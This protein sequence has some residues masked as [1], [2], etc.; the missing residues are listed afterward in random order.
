MFNERYVIED[1]RRSLMEVKG[2]V[3]THV[4]D[5]QLEIFTS[6]E[7]LPFERRRDGA[8]RQ[9]GPGD[10]WGDLFDCA[11]FHCTA[12][13]PS[14]SIGQKL[15][16][17]LDI[18]G[19]G[20][21]Y[22]DAGCPVRGITNVNSGFDRAMGNPGKRVVP[23]ADPYTGREIADFWMD[24]GCNDLVGNLQDDGRIKE[25]YIASCDETARE[26]FYDGIV[27][28]TQAEMTPQVD[29]MRY[30]LLDT[31]SRCHRLLRRYTQE[32]YRECLKLTRRQLEKK[33]GDGAGLSLTAFGHAHIDLAWLW[34][35]RETRRKGARTFATALS[36]MERYPDYRFA[37]S[38]GQLYQWVKED[39][40]ALY[41][42]VRQ[43][44]SAGR[45]EL[46]GAMWVESDANLVSGESLV[47]QL[48]YG[49][50]FWEKEFGQRSRFVWM[51]D[52]FGYSAAMPQIF[53]KSEIT[54]FATIK[55]SWNL[56]NRFPYA[57]FRWRGIDGSEVLV[58]MPP[59]GNYVS[60]ATPKSVFK[61]RKSLAESGQFG[62]ALLPFGIGDGGGGP[63]P[64]HLEYLKRE[65]NLPGLCPIEQG[66][67]QG[68]F[69]RLAQRQDSLPV[70]QNEMYLERHLGVYTSAA[71]NKKYNRQME[72]E[73]RNAEMLSAF[74]AR[75][76]GM[77]Y[78]QRE[79]EELWKETLL[80]QFHDILPGSSIQR[81]YDESLARYAVMLE[82]ARALT[83]AAAQRLAQQVDTG[84]AEKPAVVF[85]T[86]SFQ[87]DCWLNTPQ[88]IL[89]V[90]V[91][92][93][94]YTVVDMAQCRL[95]GCKPADNRVL[96]NE[97][98]RAEFA[99]DGSLVRLYRKDLER[100]L[101]K[102]P[103]N[104][105]LLYRDV[106]NAWNLQYDYTNQ[107]PERMVLAEAAGERQGG[108]GRLRQRYEYQDT[109]VELTWILRLGQPFLEAE[110]QA[111]WH[112]YDT[113]LRIAFT[114]AVH[115]E[116]V[117]SEIQFGCISRSAL[118]NT[119]QEQAQIEL[120]AHRFIAVGEPGLRFALL[121]DC[122]YGYSMR[123]GVLELNALRGTNYPGKDLDQGKHSFRYALYADD[124]P[125]LAQVTRQAH[126]FNTVPVVCSVRGGKGALAGTDSFLRVTADD[127]LID[128]VKK[129]EE[130][131]ALVIRTYETAGR[132]ARC[133]LEAGRLGSELSIANLMERQEKPTDGSCTYRPFDIVTY[134][135]R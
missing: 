79:L 64:C 90:S 34:P 97:I 117:E 133:R 22:D 48:L 27:L 11:W 7:P 82:Q 13:I 120:A 49:N 104:L 45:W 91:P 106:E 115:A 87:R 39:H 127:V 68:F 132:T 61:A 38:Q 29:P 17:I 98:L 33:G 123:E 62:E 92:A 85:N 103:S 118:D 12:K 54:G 131:E 110:V 69:D 72:L 55:M 24:A 44:V 63:S 121:N 5:M 42:K 47:R 40:P 10:K 94:G 58:H 59:E 23:F 26:L 126:A 122:K 31:L 75:L 4:A 3:Y 78:P 43:A 18:N 21:L 119:S 88:G 36:L 89:R 70:W 2:R 15:V 32:E 86:L 53:S 114:P 99:E 124:Q 60:E 1:I 46:Q 8:Y 35:L 20:L 52:T 77:T 129:A 108:I 28:L 134:M 111:D 112:Q 113:M 56:I 130:S 57:S 107:I 135:V 105:M 9:V 109:V 65:K 37:A 128:T 116:R 81:V 25:A 80:Y 95:D 16:Y 100:E 74:G 125:D 19:E 14:S 30:E 101:L 66:S 84:G 96:E 51:P 67:M 83:A 93:M 102:A 50:A 6:K 73:L 41:E 71:R 76:T